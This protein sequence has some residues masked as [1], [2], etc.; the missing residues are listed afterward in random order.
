LVCSGSAVIQICA[1]HLASHKDGAASINRQ[2]QATLCKTVVA[3][4]LVPK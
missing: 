4:K 2:A 1:E 3:A